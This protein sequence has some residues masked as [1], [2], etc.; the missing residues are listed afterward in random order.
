MS[1]VSGPPE[2][3]HPYSGQPTSFDDF[4]SFVALGTS[5]RDR[6][7]SDLR[8]LH[9]ETGELW[10]PAGC[11]SGPHLQAEVARLT[12]AG[13]FRGITGSRLMNFALGAHFYVEVTVEGEPDNLVVDPFGVAS[14][15][16]DYIEEP[17]TIIPFFGK[18]ALAP[19]HHRLIYSQSRNTKRVFIA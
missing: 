3:L 12:E 13:E 18:A 8:R 17:R 6:F 11:R 15:N 14:P 10:V 19:E 4:E 9:Q 7:V 16:R 1:L 2:R 5:V